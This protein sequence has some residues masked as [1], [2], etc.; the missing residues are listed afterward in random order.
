VPLSGQRRPRLDTV[1]CARRQEVPHRSGPPRQ[2]LDER[3]ALALVEAVTVHEAAQTHPRPHTSLGRFAGEG[4][5]AVGGIGEVPQP[6]PGRRGVPVDD[7]P[8]HA[9]RM[10]EIPCGENVMND[11]FGSDVRDDHLPPR[12]GNRYEL[13]TAQR[14]VSLAEAGP[15]GST[16]PA[17]SRHPRSARR[18]GRRRD[19]LHPRFGRPQP[20]LPHRRSALSRRRQLN[21]HS[22]KGRQV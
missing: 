18:P 14:S 6:S 16:H 2:Q 17:P 7:R 5:D 10:D 19:P 1:R 4:E 15:P 11:Q 13:G 20:P 3:S 12:L 8:P 21:G 9:R 22:I